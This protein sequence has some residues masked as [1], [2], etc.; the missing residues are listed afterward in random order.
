[1]GETLCYGWIDGIRRRI[2]DDRYEI[3]F[4]PRSPRSKWSAVNVRMM[5]ELEAAGKM[6]NAGR[7]VFQNRQDPESMGYTYE[8]EDWK[9]DTD[10]LRAF[11]TNKSAWKFFGTQPPGYRKKSIGWIMSAKKE[12]TKDQRLAQL[13]E[14]SANARRS[15]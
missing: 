4:T 3:R 15:F 8:N 2:D 7:A 13:M 9:L 10:R 5:G 14:A 1:V 11:K 12:E 6:T